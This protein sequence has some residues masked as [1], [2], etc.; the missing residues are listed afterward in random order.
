MCSGRRPVGDEEP[1][2]CLR[3]RSCQSRCFGTG[4][5]PRRA[6]RCDSRSASTRLVSVTT[7][8]FLSSGT[9][10]G[11]PDESE[12][13]RLPSWFSMSTSAEGS[14]LVDIRADG[15]RVISG[16]S[17]VTRSDRQGLHRVDAQEL[18]ALQFEA[19]V[20]EPGN[21]DRQ[22][23]VLRPRQARDCAAGRPRS[24][25]AAGRRP[26]RHQ[27][28]LQC[29]A[30]PPGR[31]W[32]PGPRLDLNLTSGGSARIRPLGNSTSA[33][34]RYSWICFTCFRFSGRW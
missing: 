9:C 20:H 12:E 10:R 18:L 32:R 23:A 19:S 6:I 21:R 5:A 8:A 16:S 7:A 17:S 26:R 22:P 24:T 15:T 1:A 31:R 34:S 4:T 28:D 14:C 29:A 3:C 27:R 30:I 25:P 2:G 33:L 11:A 13:R